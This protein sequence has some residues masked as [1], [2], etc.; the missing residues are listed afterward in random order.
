M[1]IEEI[2]IS[3]PVWREEVLVTRGDRCL[4]FVK[5]DDDT[6]YMVLDE[7]GNG[8]THTWRGGIDGIVDFIALADMF[9]EVYPDTGGGTDGAG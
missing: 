7:H 8:T 3:D 9:D 2:H 5:Y 6:R 1:C 4:Y